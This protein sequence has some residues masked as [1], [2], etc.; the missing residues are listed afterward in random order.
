MAQKNAEFLAPPKSRFRVPF[1]KK[2]II[3]KSP[4]SPDEKAPEDAAC[5]RLLKRVV[6]KIDEHQRVFYAQDSHSILC[7]FQAMDA[8][9]EDSTIRAVLSGLNPAGFP[10]YA[11][12]NSSSQDLGHD[13]LWR[14]ARCLPE[15]ERIGIFNRSYYEEVLIVRVHPE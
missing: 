7:I 3:K 10:V 8:A 4:N 9:D 5:K 13:F 15:R 6:D 2:F 12:K 1:D 14:T 11:F